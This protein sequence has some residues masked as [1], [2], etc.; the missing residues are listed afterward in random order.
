MDLERFAFADHT[1]RTEAQSNHLA[2]SAQVHQGVI[3]AL[4]DE[5]ASNLFLSD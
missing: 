4:T 1:D 5:E 3:S 2:E